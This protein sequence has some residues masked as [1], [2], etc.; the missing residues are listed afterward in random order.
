[1]AKFYK[2]IRFCKMCKK[3]FVPAEKVAGFSYGSGA[4]CPECCEKYF[5][6]EKE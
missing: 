6:K 2:E 1:M 4:Y 3:R 5:K